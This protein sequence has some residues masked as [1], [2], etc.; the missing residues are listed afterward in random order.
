MDDAS[1]DFLWEQGIKVAVN[2]VIAELPESTR[3]TYSVYPDFSEKNKKQIKTNYNNL[4]RIVRNDFF[5]TGENNENR[6]DGH[7]ICACLTGAIQS[8]PLI[9]FDPVDEL[10]PVELLY[11]RSAAAFISG[12]N[13]LYLFMLSDYKKNNQ[14]EYFEELYKRATLAF[15]KTNEGHDEYVIG[16]I[17]ALALNELYGIDF[18]ILAYADMLFWI[19]L[20][21]KKLL[22]HYFKNMNM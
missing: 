7:K 13:I 22:E 14:E 11:A 9:K 8:V 5:N 15:P 4:R 2:N 20:Y 17:K 19:E 18:D 12:I 1:F 6:I 21:N 10:V 3:N 16:R